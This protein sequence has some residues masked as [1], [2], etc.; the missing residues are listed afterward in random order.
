MTQEVANPEQSQNLQTFDEEKILLIKSM[1]AR[2]CTDHEFQMLIHLANTY[3]LDPLARQIWAVKYPG[4]PAQ[5]FCGRDGFLSIAHRSGVFNGIESGVKKCDSE[6]V[7]WAKVHRKDMQFPFYVEVFEKEYNSGKS[8]WKTKPRTMIKKVAESQA[9][10]QAFSVSGLYSP[11]E[12]GDVPM[13]TVPMKV[14]D[15]MPQ[16]YDPTKCSICGLPTQENL[17][18]TIAEKTG[19][20]P[21]CKNCFRKWWDE[22]IQKKAEK[23]AEVQEGFTA[24]VKEPETPKAPEKPT[25]PETKP[26]PAPSAEEPAPN[27]PQTQATQPSAGT[28]SKCG[29]PISK[30]ELKLSNMCFGRILCTNCMNLA[31]KDSEYLK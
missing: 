3:G 30:K 24:T 8:V 2:D 6:W 18:D 11:E 19:G 14:L 26:E 23:A 22:Q 10:R 28:C 20:V 31:D 13:Q 21:M 17:R 25:P 5:I 16:S 29:G 7:G 12:M 4:S 15:D 27:A 1:C 9:L